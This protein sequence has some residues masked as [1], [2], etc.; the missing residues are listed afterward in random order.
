MVV[1][2]KFNTRTLH[3]GARDAAPKSPERTEGQPGCLIS[4]LMTAFAVPLGE[5]SELRPMQF[6]SVRLICRNPNE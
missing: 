3:K 4:L 6:V 2:V 1:K 5:F